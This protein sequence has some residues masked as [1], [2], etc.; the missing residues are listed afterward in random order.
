[1]GIIQRGRV[2][3]AVGGVVVLFGALVAWLVAGLA[4]TAILVFVLPEFEPLFENSG[5]SLPPSTQ[6]II[7]VGNFIGDFWWL[8]LMMVAGADRNPSSLSKPFV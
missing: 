2:G 3:H 7:A 5:A 1:M 8:I 6:A 4:V